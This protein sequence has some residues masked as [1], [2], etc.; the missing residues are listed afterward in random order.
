MYQFPQEQNVHCYM[1]IDP[2]LQCITSYS[3][4]YKPNSSDWY[5]GYS[6]NTTPNL[7]YTCLNI[8]TILNETLGKLTRLLL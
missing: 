1:Q 3:V 5:T 2:N 8:T 7:Q 6:I 4:Y